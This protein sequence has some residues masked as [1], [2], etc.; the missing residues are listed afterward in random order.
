[1]RVQGLTHWTD[2]ARVAFQAE[3]AGLMAGQAG[4]SLDQVDEPLRGFLR[5]AGITESEWANLTDPRFMFQ[6]SN[7]ATF[8]SPMWWRETTDMPEKQAD[9][10]FFK[11]QG[12]IEEQMEYAVPTQSL[13][14]R[15]AVDPAA[16]D[17]PPG[18][19]VYEVAKSGL[20][21]KSFAMTFTVN[22]FRRISSQQTLGGKIGYAMNL[23]AGATVMGAL[24]V[25][26]A[27]L[28]S[29]RDPQDMTDP[30]FWAQATLKGGGFGIMG[31]I[32]SAGQTQ[33]GGGFGSY[34]MGP[35]P[36]LAQDVW[37]LTVY[38]AWQMAMGEE[39]NFA[40]ELARMGKR[41]T[42]MGQT[43]A[44]GPAMDR[45]FWDQLAIMLDP[46]AQSA[47]AAASQRRQNLYG[48]AEWWKPGAAL[49]ARAPDFGAALP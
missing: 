15:G 32:V 48:N 21:F 5:G 8:A 3:F 47:L 27:Q 38:N 25:Q 29:G 22:Q 16:Y 41:Y 24:S 35:M 1:M 19:L 23:A 13:L 2:M 43:P 45:M 20:M 9:D 4:R 14:A 30:G 49:P 31:D 11:I 46:E 42:P 39:T 28:W 10:L 33:W 34:L 37:G 44:I 40:Y 6:A 17:L 18:S 12:L 26:I 36:Q 7:G